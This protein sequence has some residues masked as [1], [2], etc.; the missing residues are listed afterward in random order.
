MGIIIRQS[1]KGTIVNYVG[2]FIG[3]VITFAITTKFLTAEE[4]GLVRILLEAGLLF[5]PYRKWELVLPQFDFIL[6][7]KTKK[8]KTTAFSFGQSSSL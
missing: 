8:I 1:I 2:A 7:L 4:I 5:A 6:I 3:F